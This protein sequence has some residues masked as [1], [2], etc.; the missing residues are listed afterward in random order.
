[1]PELPEVETIARQLRELVVGRRISEFSSLW[2]R[3]TEPLPAKHFAKVGFH[4]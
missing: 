1:M 3:V 2:H 4:G